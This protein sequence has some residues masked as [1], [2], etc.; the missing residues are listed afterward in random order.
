ML[1]YRY[2]LAQ[3]TL[4]LE[5]LLNREVS[6]MA[7]LPDDSGLAV[8]E[9]GYSDDLTNLF[10]WRDGVKTAVANNSGASAPAPVPL[11]SDPSHT[12]LLLAPADKGDRQYGLLDVAG[13]LHGDCALDTLDGYPAWSPDLAHMILLRSET[14]ERIWRKPA[15]TYS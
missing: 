12:K 11:R 3:A 10:L 13:C 1:F 2:D 6:V 7:A 9:A 8:W 14:F 15:A 4:Q 5:Q